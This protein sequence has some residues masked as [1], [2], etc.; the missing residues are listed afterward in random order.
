MG[1]Q[2]ELAWESGLD[3]Y[4]GDEEHYNECGEYYDFDDKGCD[5]EVYWRQKNGVLIAI[6][7]MDITHVRNTV[8][9][10]RRKDMANLIPTRMIERLKDEDRQK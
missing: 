6:D 8:R 3:D 9:M 2:A 5:S 10:L 7:E 1:E 4:H